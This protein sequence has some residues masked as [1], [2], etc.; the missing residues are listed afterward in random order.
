[1]PFQFKS[2]AIA[3]VVIVTPKQFVDRRGYF[4]ETY[5]ASDFEALGI[6]TGFIQHNQAMSVERGTLRGLHF[7][8][9]PFAQAKLI[10]VLK[11]AIF[12]VA[13]DLRQGS[14]DYGKWVGS[15]MSAEGAEQLFVPQGFAHGYC[16]MEPGTEVAYMCDAYYAADHEGGINFADPDLAIDWP[17]PASEAVLVERDRALPLLRDF[18]SPFSL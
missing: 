12:D 9:P 6:K 17:I 4:M 8:R 7:Q 14:P 2:L 13:V 1:M 15:T 16:T 3:E 11:G 18:V 5:R 10:R